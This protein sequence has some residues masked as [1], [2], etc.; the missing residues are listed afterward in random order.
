MIWNEGGGGH[1]MYFWLRERMR[2]VG[3]GGHMRSTV[4]GHRPDSIDNSDGSPGESRHSLNNMNGAATR[5]SRNRYVGSLKASDW[6]NSV[7]RNNPNRSSWTV[8]TS[9]LRSDSNNVLLWMVVV[10]LLIHNPGDNS[11]TVVSGGSRGGVDQTNCED[12]EDGEEGL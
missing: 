8:A 2:M 10:V 4:V 7:S 6:V 12:G 11:T 3:N 1:R 5:S 9:F